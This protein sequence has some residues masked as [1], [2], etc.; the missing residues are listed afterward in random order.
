MRASEKKTR[1]SDP[2]KGAE[3]AALTDALKRVRDGERVWVTWKGQRLL[4]TTWDGREC[5]DLLVVT[6]SFGVI[7][8]PCS[9]KDIGNGGMRVNGVP[10]RGPNPIVRGRRVL[11]M[12]E[13]RFSR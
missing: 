7:V 2:S 9:D 3:R 8:S 13:E 5:A 11:A 1:R 10:T 4:L 12:V 6:R